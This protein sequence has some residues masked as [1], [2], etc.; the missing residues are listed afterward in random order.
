MKKVPLLLL[1]LVITANAMAQDVSYTPDMEAVLGKREMKK[2]GKLCSRKSY[3][4]KPHKFWPVDEVSLQSLHENFQKLLGLTDNIGQKVDTLPKYV[5]QYI[6]IVIKGEEYI[7]INAFDKRNLKYD[8][9]DWRKETVNVC[10]G[11]TNYWGVLY[12]V[13]TGTF[14]DLRFNGIG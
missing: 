2:M 8:T 7:Y 14:S 11:R 13:K 3:G 10:D 4:S 6:G 12:H 1:L 5:F 9:T